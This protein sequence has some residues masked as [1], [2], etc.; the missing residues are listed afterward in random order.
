MM[1]VQLNTLVIQPFLVLGSAC[2][3]PANVATPWAVAF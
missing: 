2:L 1:A 3:V